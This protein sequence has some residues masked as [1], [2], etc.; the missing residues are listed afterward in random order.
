VVKRSLQAHDRPEMEVSKERQMT[1]TETSQDQELQ[2]AQK[3]ISHRI[4][5]FFLGL[6]G[7]MSLVAAVAYLALPGND[8]TQTMPMAGRMMAAT[9]A[10]TVTVAMRDPGC[11]WFQQG[12][13]FTK[14]MSVTGPVNLQN[15]D[16]AA[17]KVAGSSGVQKDPMGGQ[18]ALG[19]GSYTITMVGQAPDDNTLHLQ[20]S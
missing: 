13:S 11:H 10:Q 18:V 14:S 17:L 16:E 8:Q 3:R 19:P 6:I 9:P 7:I 2:Q 12:Q 15:S 5:G 1:E 4:S 20:V